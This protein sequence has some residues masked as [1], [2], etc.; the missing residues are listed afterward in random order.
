VTGDR[1]LGAPAGDPAVDVL[2]GSTAGVGQ[3]QGEE[4]G[5]TP[6]QNFTTPPPKTPMVGPR[7]S[8]VGSFRGMVRRVPVPQMPVPQI[9]RSVLNHCLHFGSHTNSLK[10]DEQ[11]LVTRPPA[12]EL[13]TY[14]LPSPSRSRLG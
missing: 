7:T 9:D 5:T 12:L 1:L 11:N 2:T 3:D 8:M 6:G 13:A 10:N 14:S 4:G